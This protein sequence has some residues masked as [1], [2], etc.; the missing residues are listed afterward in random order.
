MR[1]AEK[2][3]K[4]GQVESMFHTFATPLKTRCILEA[5]PIAPID[6]EGARRQLERVVGEPGFLRNERMSRIP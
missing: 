1:L 4:S 3:G 6:P 5:V 2:K